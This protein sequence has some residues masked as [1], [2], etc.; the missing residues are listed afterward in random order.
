MNERN[1]TEMQEAAQD[2][3]LRAAAALPRAI[4]PQRDLWPGIEQALR[5]QQRAG[6]WRSGLFAQ[7][8]SV[9]LLVGVSSGLTYLAVSPPDREVSPVSVGVDRV[10]EPVSGSF[11]SRYNLG[12][13]FQAARD[14]LAARLDLEMAKLSPETRAVVQKNLDAIRAVIVEI[15]KALAAEPDNEL[16]QEM[17]IRS[18]HDELALMQKVGGIGNSAMVRND[19]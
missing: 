3:L 4:Q 19:I 11:G 6:G 18:Y 15:N 14:V 9:I 17:L 12:P 1:E 16:L 5:A 10:F 2:A 13:D 8:A 7:A